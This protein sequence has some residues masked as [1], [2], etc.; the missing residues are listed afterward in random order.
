MMNRY[1]TEADGTLIDTTPLFSSNLM[2]LFNVLR[3]YFVNR[4]N[5]SISNVYD[6]ES[7]SR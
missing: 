2:A 3:E 7:T 5:T 6:N 1:E 4:R